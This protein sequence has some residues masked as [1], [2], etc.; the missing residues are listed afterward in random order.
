MK[1]F[2]TFGFVLVLTLLV[3]YVFQLNTLISQTHKVQLYQERL[4]ELSESNKVLEV[5]LAKLNYLDNIPAKS[6]ELGFERV[7]AI[8]YI[9][10]L[11]TVAAARQQ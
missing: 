1:L 8:N 11:D 4:Q 9:Q 10:V 7:G 3:F 6:Q 5:Q 2:Y